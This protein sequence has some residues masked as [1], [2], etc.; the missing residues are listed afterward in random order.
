[1]A[2]S[3][4]QWVLDP[5]GN[6]MSVDELLL[7]VFPEANTGTGEA[8]AVAI[9]QPASPAPEEIPE[10]PIEDPTVR[11]S[12]RPGRPTQPRAAPFEPITT[13]KR[14]RE[15]DDDNIGPS[16]GRKSRTC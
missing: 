4:G 9:T 3:A 13:M 16:R 10:Q 11:R 6:D 7:N 14:K 5:D 8:A 2:S 1:M 12:G 15:D